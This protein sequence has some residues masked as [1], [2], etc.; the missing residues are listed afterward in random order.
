M[1]P[2]MI[3]RHLSHMHCNMQAARTCHDSALSTQN[4]QLFRTLTNQS[5]QSSCLLEPS[6]GESMRH[7]QALP[8]LET[9]QMPMFYP[10]L[11]STLLTSSLIRAQR[12]QC[13]DL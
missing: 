11:I 8:L 6:A 12:Q 2:A 7:N 9:N 3:V 1:H 10:L 5:N 4:L 13:R